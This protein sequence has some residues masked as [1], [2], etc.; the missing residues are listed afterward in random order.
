MI[1]NRKETNQNLETRNVVES[2]IERSKN[3]KA[4]QYATTGQ[5]NRMWDAIENKE[6]GIEPAPESE[7]SKS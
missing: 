3:N 7:P 6:T 5:K 4:G 2:A 1:A